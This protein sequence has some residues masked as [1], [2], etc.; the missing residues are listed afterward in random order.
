MSMLGTLSLTMLQ[1]DANLISPTQQSALKKW[2][3]IEG[4]IGLISTSSAKTLEI[5]HLYSLLQEPRQ[6]CMIST[7]LTLPRYLIST[8]LSSH[9]WQNGSQMSGYLSHIT[10]PPPWQR[11]GTCLMSHDL[12]LTDWMVCLRIR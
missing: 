2:S 3:L 5:F 6:N 7:G 1:Y 8:L 10:G 4:I 11:L 12:C 9:A